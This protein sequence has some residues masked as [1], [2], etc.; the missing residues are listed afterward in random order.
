MANEKGTISCEAEGCAVVCGE[1]NYIRCPKANA[2]QSGALVSP[3]ADSSI[4][5]TARHFWLTTKLTIVTT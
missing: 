4:L 1:T 5:F 2:C 3:C